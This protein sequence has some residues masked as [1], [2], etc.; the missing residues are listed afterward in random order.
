MICD[1]MDVTL[2]ENFVTAQRIMTLLCVCNKTFYTSLVFAS[3]AYI[4]VVC[5]SFALLFQLKLKFLPILLGQIQEMC[6]YSVAK[7]VKN[8]YFFFVV[9]FSS[10]KEHFKVSPSNICGVYIFLIRSRASIFSYRNFN[11]FILFANERFVIV[12]ILREHEKK[13]T[14]NIIY[15]KHYFYFTYLL[16]T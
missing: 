1:S 12:A 11:S 10:T 2:L 15:N 14:K 5:L 4:L 6:V 13:Q 8:F 16:S 3:K 7:K 9:F